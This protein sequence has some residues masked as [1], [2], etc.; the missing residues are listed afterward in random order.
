MIYDNCLHR[1]HCSL[2]NLCE[3]SDLGFL[4]FT[5]DFVDVLDANHLHLPTDWPVT[6]TRLFEHE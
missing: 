2:I 1:A 5:P 3:H 6:A 4:W